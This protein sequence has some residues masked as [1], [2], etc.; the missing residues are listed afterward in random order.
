[1]S[2]VEED[3]FDFYC[4]SLIHLHIKVYEDGRRQENECTE[5]VYVKLLEE[6]E[7]FEYYFFI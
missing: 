6:V 5:A 2:S 1:M 3:M 4:Y 7:C